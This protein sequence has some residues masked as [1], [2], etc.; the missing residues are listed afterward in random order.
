[1]FNRNLTLILV[2]LLL[3]SFLFVNAN[4]PA[5]YYEI[6]HLSYAASV[7]LSKQDTV[8]EE[9][10]NL[11]KLE[12]EQAM[13]RVQ[14]DD[15]VEDMM[16]D[17]I[18]LGNAVTVDVLQIAASVVMTTA[19][20][21][22]DI[23]DAVALAS[24]RASKNFDISMQ[25]LHVQGRVNE[26]DTA[27]KHY[28]AHYDAY[29]AKYSGSLELITKGGTPDQL[30][31]DSGL[32]VP[33]ANPKCSTTWSTD[34]ISLSTAVWAAY[35]K[36][37]V[38]CNIPHEPSID[39]P[40][41]PNPATYWN[42]PDDPRSKCPYARLHKVLCGGECGTWLSRRGLL[43]G[44]EP[45]DHWVSCNE[46]VKGTLENF[47]DTNCR[48]YYYN[49]NGDTSA[50][51]WNASNHIGG[52]SSNTVNPSA[53]LSGSSSASAGDS[54]SFSLTTSA[55]FSKVDWY[56]AGPGDS[57]LG[58]KVETD[59]GGSLSKSASLSYTFSDSGSYTITASIHNYRYKSVYKSTY[60]VD[61]TPSVAPTNP[62]VVPAPPPPPTV[63]PNPPT[64]PPSPTLTTCRRCGVSYDPNSSE[65]SQH[66]YQTF[67][68]GVHS[69]YP[70]SNKWMEAHSTERT[71]RLCGTTF[72]SCNN[73]G[74][75][76]S[77]RGTF[78]KHSRVR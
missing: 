32:S 74:P 48:G 16:E 59:T 30:K 38:T 70:C 45:R 44:A 15:N 9:W 72:Y 39:V 8:I 24:A 63:T 27:Y 18:S 17:A 26:R 13:L 28:K 69:G 57:G 36:H 21:I 23:A 67:A 22:K 11:D 19:N 78:P 53:S 43:P 29:V 65:A 42:C 73:N 34:G 49:C 10:K 41:P 31:V 47:W 40:R 61:V 7:Y 54:V 6:G 71:C 4:D 58:T 56:V 37:L 77:D 75:C 68:C 60:T 55:A 62:V 64:P 46:T 2:T 35:N 14:W 12:I 25:N 20:S 1:M 50:D 5:T 66:T 33:C 76:V 3:G 51:C 52:S